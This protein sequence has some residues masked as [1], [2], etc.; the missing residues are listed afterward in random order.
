MSP[1]SLQRHFGQA[2]WYDPGATI[3]NFGCGGE[4][5]S[6]QLLAVNRLTL[7]HGVAPREPAEVPPGFCLHQLPRL[8]V[9]ERDGMR[10]LLAGEWLL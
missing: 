6:G 8:L 1:Y 7:G 5:S 4:H 10:Q 3:L 9:D 2:L